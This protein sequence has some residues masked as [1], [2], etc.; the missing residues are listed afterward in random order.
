[1]R[2]NKSASW[3]PHHNSIWQHW[4]FPFLSNPEIERYHL[5]HFHF[6][7]YLFISFFTFDFRMFDHL[8]FTSIENQCSDSSLSSPQSD[9]PTENSSPRPCQKTWTQ[10]QLQQMIMLEVISDSQRMHHKSFG[11]FLHSQECITVSQPVE[12]LAEWFNN[13]DITNCHRFEWMIHNSCFFNKA[14]SLSFSHSHVLDRNE[15]DEFV[16]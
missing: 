9:Y 12:L 3:Y 1:L 16:L 14:L 15:I 2:F 6:I 10:H 4:H 8:E 5:H 7:S 13:L 11:K